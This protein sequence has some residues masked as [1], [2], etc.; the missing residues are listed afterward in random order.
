MDD[1]PDGV[2]IVFVKFLM[3]L[4]SSISS[5]SSKPSNNGCQVSHELVDFNGNI[6]GWQFG[7]FSQV[8]HELVDF[9]LCSSFSAID[10]A[11]KFLRNL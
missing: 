7:L 6:C 9:N 11:V 8:S 3:N 4:W 5:S 1:I 10:C 2:D